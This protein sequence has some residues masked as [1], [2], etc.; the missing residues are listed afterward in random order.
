MIPVSERDQITAEI[1][2]TCV[3][4]DNEVIKIKS[5]LTKHTPYSIYSFRIPDFFIFDLSV[6]GLIFSISAAP[7]DP[8]TRPLHFFYTARIC[9]RSFS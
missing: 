9:S 2:R 3:I 1:D 8:H 5:C 4:H 6:D 7:E